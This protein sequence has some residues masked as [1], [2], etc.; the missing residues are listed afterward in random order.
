MRQYV[1]DEGNAWKN[2]RIVW[3]GSYIL[4]TEQLLRV[5]SSV[6]FW[7]GGRCGRVQKPLNNIHCA[8]RKPIFYLPITGDH[9]KIKLLR[10][11]S[12]E[13]YPLRPSTCWCSVV[14]NKPVSAF[15]REIILELGWF[16][17]SR[18]YY[19]WKKPQPPDT[20]KVT[21]TIVWLCRLLYC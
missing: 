20:A 6:E 9:L 18:N 17:F 3:D 21:L 2:G 5:S 1:I 15:W 14:K 8:W 4:C 11:G 10:K 12:R 7:G 16:C 13:C 19:L